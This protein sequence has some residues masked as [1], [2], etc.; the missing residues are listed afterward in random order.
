MFA[1]MMHGTIVTMMLVQTMLFDGFSRKRRDNEVR[2]CF[3]K[4]NLRAPYSGLRRHSY[5]PH[6][7][8][9]TKDDAVSGRLLNP[10]LLVHVIEHE[11]MYECWEMRFDLFLGISVRP[12]P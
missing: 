11:S 10:A 5:H 6:P 8:S 3:G 1:P 4:S 7:A 2:G 9:T 12:K